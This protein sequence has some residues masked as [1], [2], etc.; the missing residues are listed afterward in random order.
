MKLGQ[1]LRQAFAPPQAIIPDPSAGDGDDPSASPT[2]PPQPA[3]HRP[4]TWEVSAW[5]HVGQVRTQNQDR[6]LTLQSVTSTGE[7]QLLPLGLFVVAD[8]MGGHAD[9]DMASEIA[10]RAIAA[11]TLPELPLSSVQQQGRPIHEILTDAVLAAHQDILRQGQHQ[12]MGTTAT[13]ALLVGTALYLAHVG[14][15]RAYVLDS[16]GLHPV[17][18]DHSVVARLQELRQITAQEAPDHP[19]RNVLY[20]ALGQSEE[21]EIETYYHRLSGVSHV[22]LCSDGLWNMVPADEMT[23]ILEE[24]SSAQAACETLIAAANA[25]GGEDN[26]T[27]ILL[28]LPAA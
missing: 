3:P 21:L 4:S 15:T 26:I 12:G 18:R 22:M 16:T 6:F 23:R 10:L 7:A 5:S 1:R 24:A 28:R 8:G 13:V 19:Q 11:H 17:T 25:A 9:G 27:V 20:R 14:D 2:P